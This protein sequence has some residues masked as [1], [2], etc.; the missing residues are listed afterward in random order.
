[1]EEMISQYVATSGYMKRL[2]DAYIEIRIALNDLGYTEKTAEK[3]DI[4]SPEL[5]RAHL[6]FTDAYRSLKNIVEEFF[7]IDNWEPYNT[8]KDRLNQLNELFPLNDGD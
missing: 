2:V 7:G 5:H 3:V 6:E 4:I 8:I 1:M